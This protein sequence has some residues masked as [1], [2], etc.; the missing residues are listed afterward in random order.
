[1][2]WRSA[3]EPPHERQPKAL[4][5]WDR[6][7]HEWEDRAIEEERW[8]GTLHGDMADAPG[9]QGLGGGVDEARLSR[10]IASMALAFGW[11]QPP[12]AARVFTPAFLPRERAA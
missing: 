12:P 3:A 1:M 5:D 8:R 2:P 9:A 4:G 11:P 6:V 10:A 7:R